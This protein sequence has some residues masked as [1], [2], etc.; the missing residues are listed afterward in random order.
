M[1]FKELCDNINNMACVV[2]VE[3][4]GDSYGE[5]RL[6]E[7]NQKYKN[8]FVVKQEGSPA[9]LKEFIPNSIYTEYIEKNINFEQ[10]CY[11]SAI[12]KE[13]LHSYAYPESLGAWF[14]MLYIPLEYETDTHGFCL[15]IMDVHEAFDSSILSSASND[16]ANKVLKTT[17]QLS[18]SKNFIETLNHIVKDIRE[19]CNAE[20]CCILVVDK[21]KEEVVSLAEDR[22]STSNRKKM[23]YYINREFSQLVFTWHETLGDNNCIIISNL[24]E[25]EFL[26]EKNIKWYN[27]LKE[28]NVNSLVL[29]PLKSN[30][31]LIGYMW[32]NNF[33][34]IDTIKIKETLEITTFILESEISNYLLLKKLKEMSSMDVLTGLQ[35]RNAMN[36]YMK[37]FIEADN[38]LSIGVIFLD[39][40]G[41]KK[42]NDVLGH[43]KGDALIKRAAH[44][45]KSVFDTI[46]IFRSGGDEFIIIL[47]DIS[48]EEI[49]H[50]I[51]RIKEESMKNDISFAVGYS[52]KKSRKDV[53][54][55][56][57]DADE[58]MYIDKREHYKSIR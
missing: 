18:N 27:S 38:D 6:V 50:Y 28:S 48:E 22:V 51:E 11:N 16:V 58:N 24:H 57:K 30:D 26:K 9:V 45:L 13:L 3:K 46:P 15:Y 33:K 35:N 12:K 39:I 53:L 31:R 2:S 32:V 17:L 44:T 5:I 54:K 25:M 41:L 20:F 52:L 19:M 47:D 40:N 23:G 42:V 14:H 55:A 56:L 43:L 21:D 8:S 29:F 37:R 36:D 1:H 34:D 49:I 7:G 10:F 4:K